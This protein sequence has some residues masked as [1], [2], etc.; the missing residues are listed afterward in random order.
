[1]GDQL[2][3]GIKHGK[4]C[5]VSSAQLWVWTQSDTIAADDQQVGV[6]ATLLPSVSAGNGAKS[7]CST[8]VKIPRRQE[9][10]RAAR[11]GRA[12][13]EEP[14][15]AGRWGTAGRKGHASLCWESSGR[16]V[17]AGS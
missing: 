9:T 4:R 8:E 10:G 5:G 17:V 14:K 16:P 2:A 7:A 3:S 12:E 13:R 11:G 1:M 6:H 15:A